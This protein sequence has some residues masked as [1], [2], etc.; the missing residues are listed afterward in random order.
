MGVSMSDTALPRVSDKH[1]RT[2]VSSIFQAVGVPLQDA[3]ITADALVAADLKGRHSHGTSRTATYVRRIRRRV[4]NPVPQISSDG[5]IGPITRLDGD[6]GL[7]QVGA[8]EAVAE[9]SF[10]AQQYGLAAVA[11]YN[12]NHIGMVGYYTEAAARRNLICL[13]LANA[14][15]H[16]AP[17]GG[18]TPVLGTNPLSVG[19]PRQD[20][21]PIVLDM[22]TSRTAR[23]NIILAAGGSQPIP[24]DW[25]LDSTGRPT[26]DAKEA[27]AG[28]VLPM[29]GPKGYGLALV[30]DVMA[31]VLTGANFN[32]GV[33]AMTEEGTEPL[34]C[35]AFFIGIA[36]GAFVGDHEFGY[37]TEHLVNSIKSSRV[38]PGFDAVYL[39]GEPESI[40]EAKNRADGILLEGTVIERLNQLALEL[41][42][43]RELMIGKMPPQ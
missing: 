7:G 10:R 35:G 29:A 23:G 43:D 32:G 33:P 41:D 13:C 39:P 26:T 38:R 36:P 1:L 12:T 24:D 27:L 4:M 17:W 34:N 30:C 25:A 20:G 8:W 15:A 16:V 5:R 42:V 28:S 2:L 19:I 9:L 18:A 3:E 31:G 6:N 40:I 21:A 14:S 11:L 22:A 37:R